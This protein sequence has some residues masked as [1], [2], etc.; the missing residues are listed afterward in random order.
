MFLHQPDEGMAVPV[1]LDFENN[2]LTV[3][4]PSVDE[5]ENDYAVYDDLS[6]ILG[7]VSGNHR[8]QV[9]FARRFS[10][11]CS[12]T[13]RD[14]LSSG[15]VTVSQLRKLVEKHVGQTAGR[16]GARVVP[17]PV[18]EEPARASLGDES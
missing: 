14:Q 6:G 2:T 12:K 13:F 9:S 8:E 11:E 7:A 10:Q 3:R 15:K 17:F 16:Q 5:L 18:A 1:L 4:V